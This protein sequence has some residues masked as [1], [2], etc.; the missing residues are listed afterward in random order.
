MR[1]EA[2]S[3]GVINDCRGIG[4]LITR[5]QPRG[6]AEMHGTSSFLASM[7]PQL[8]ADGQGYINAVYG[9]SWWGTGTAM[10]ESSHSLI[11]EG[12]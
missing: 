4:R 10:G 11:R 5:E 9:Q 2:R 3:R 6:L 7:V 12:R 1:V 8:S